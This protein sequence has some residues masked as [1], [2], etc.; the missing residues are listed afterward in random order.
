MKVKL[1]ELFL[2]EAVI[3]RNGHLNK[4]KLA[5]CLARNATIIESPIKALREHTKDTEEIVEYKKALDKLS[6]EHATKDKNGRPKFEW[7]M[8]PNT[9]RPR[10][11]DYD[12]ADQDK[13]DAA[14][15]ALKEKHGEAV[16]VMESN[17]EEFNERLKEE[18]DINFY[19]LP[20]SKMPVKYANEDDEDGEYPIPL[21][22]LT[23]LVKLGIV[24]DDAPEADEQPLKDGEEPPVVA[25]VEDEPAADAEDGDSESPK[26]KRRRRTG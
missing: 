25:P 3:I 21:Q 12:I 8:D 23:M 1:E 9:R 7:I 5:W 17:E 15:E 19:R 18:E 6:Q 26:K 22:D 13:Y 16:K 10:G 4:G 2:L 20:L 14:V 24:Y 11:K